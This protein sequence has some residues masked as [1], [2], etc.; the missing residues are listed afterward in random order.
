ML[1]ESPG[2][3]VEGF[4]TTHP[5][6]R[7]RHFSRSRMVRGDPEVGQS[8]KVTSIPFSKY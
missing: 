3:P 4:A 7:R 2:P 1:R 6:L 5:Q 8:K